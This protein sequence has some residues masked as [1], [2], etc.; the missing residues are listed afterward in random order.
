MFQGPDITVILINWIKD[1]GEDWKFYLFY[2]KSVL[3]INVEDIIETVAFNLKIDSEYERHYRKSYAHPQSARKKISLV[4]T[5]NPDESVNPVRPS[6]GNFISDVKVYP[7]GFTS[8]IVGCSYCTRGTLQCPNCFGSKIVT[9][10]ECYTYRSGKCKECRGTGEVAH[11]RCGG[12]GACHTCGGSGKVYCSGCGGSG[13]VY[14]TDQVSEKCVT[15]GGSGTRFISYEDGKFNTGI[16]IECFGNGEITKTIQREVQHLACSGTG[17]VYCS[18]C[19]GDGNCPG[20]NG[21]GKVYCSKCGGSAIC[22]FCSGNGTKTCTTC[23]GRG[24]VVCPICNGETQMFLYSSDIYDFKPIVDSNKVYPPKF[25]KIYK[26]FDKS[27]FSISLKALTEKEIS[28]KLGLV[29]GRILIIL[30]KAK[31]IFNSLLS[32]AKKREFTA[33]AAKD[34]DMQDSILK[35]QIATIKHDWQKNISDRYYSGF[36]LDFDAKERVTNHKD[37][38]NKI[39]FQNKYYNL[40]PSALINFWMGTKKHNLYTVGKKE[41]HAIEKPPQSYNI[42]SMKIISFASLI[43]TFIL[44]A[45]VYFNLLFD[46]HKYIFLPLVPLAVLYPILVYKSV[47]TEKELLITIIGENDM[48]KT[49]YFATLAHYIS[50]NK[51]G[52]IKDEIYPKLTEYLLGND[53]KL[54]TSLTYSIR[55]NDDKDVRL[56]NLS[57][58]SYNYLDTN[59]TKVINNSNSL[60]AFIDINRDIKRQVSNI[61]STIKHFQGINLAIVTNGNF[62]DIKLL[63]D[64]SIEYKIFIVELDNLND[65]FLNKDGMTMSSSVLE[66]FDYLLG[67]GKYGIAKSTK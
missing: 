11:E 49:V 23:W 67:Y 10:P 21:S 4:D 38:H 59:V 25:D 3:N 66:P 2:D 56:L 19:K 29:N 54:G 61:L 50:A 60:I 26:F 8:R 52:I 44:L 46:I 31:S 22:Q 30:D 28:N 35:R 1:L 36:K 34:H 24:E 39:I 64:S 37:I 6:A 14:T 48:H 45:L 16:C 58:S 42:S 5:E 62:A 9:C 13:R 20:C 47:K 15:C 18:E 17:R 12:S 32:V 43:I 51:K 40:I 55:F 63:D 41:K 27:E 33:T 7:R 65:T 57:S 53:L